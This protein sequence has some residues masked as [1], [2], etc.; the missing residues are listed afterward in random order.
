MPVVLT[1]GSW[2]PEDVL[3]MNVILSVFH[4]AYPDIVIEH[5]PTS[6]PDY[7]EALESQLQY[8]TAPDLFYLRSFS[9]SRRLFEA[10]YVAP[11]NDLP[12]LEEHFSRQ[13]LD[14]WGTSDGVFY[15]VPF[16]ATAHGIY[17]NQDI[18][19]ALGLKTPRTWEAPLPEAFENLLAALRRDRDEQA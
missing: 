2:R 5:D 4:N 9:I 11:L 6:A 7:N 14:A 1:L 10:G 15:G 17:Y 8:G 19:D 3:E 16:I 13:T 12:G 18:F